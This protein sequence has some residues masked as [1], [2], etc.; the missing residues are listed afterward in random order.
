MSESE[1]KL[2]Q[3]FDDLQKKYDELLDK[4]RRSLAESD[5]MRK[6]WL[7][8]ITINSLFQ[9]I[10]LIKNRLTKQ[11][12]EAKMFGIQGFCKDL[13]EVADVL[14]KAVQGVPEDTLESESKYL[15]DMYEGE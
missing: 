3:E 10:K 13:L 6:R 4:Y 9:V 8:H 11:I 15:K 14:N 2:K 12:E 1:A 5:N 7:F